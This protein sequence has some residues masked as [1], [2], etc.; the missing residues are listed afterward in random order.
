MNT[1]KDIHFRPD[2][3]DSAFNQFMVVP[4]KLESL[5]D[6]TK[7]FPIIGVGDALISAEYRLGTGVSNGVACA[8]GLMEAL[9]IHSD[10][11]EV[12]EEQWRFKVLRVFTHHEKDIT[13]LYSDARIAMDA[14]ANEAYVRY[15]V[16]EEEGVE[17]AN[18][19]SCLA[20]KFCRIAEDKSQ[21]GQIGIVELMHAAHMYERSYVLNPN[22]HTYQRLNELATLLKNTGNDAKIPPI[23]RIKLY[24]CALN[25]HDKYVPN[26][27]EEKTK[28][29]TNLGRV[30]FRVRDFANSSKYFEQAH[31]MVELPLSNRTTS[32]PIVI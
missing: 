20:N 11:I 9:R 22:E 26:A 16:S 21:L 27:W 24:T 14:A 6:T 12:I 13:D 15:S 17:V 10:N 28:I 31:N 29:R 30:C 5:V 1:G 23:D 3:D 18:D 32:Q 25:L 19:M 4:Q 7:G 8:N 2:A